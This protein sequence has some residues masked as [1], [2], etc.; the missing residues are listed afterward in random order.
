MVPRGMVLFLP[1]GH[2]VRTAT[3]QKSSRTMGSQSLFLCAA[4]AVHLVAPT[5][6]STCATIRLRRMGSTARS[7]I[8]IGLLS[9]SRP[10]P[11]STL[12]DSF[13]RVF[14]V[15]GCCRRFTWQDA[16]NFRSLLS[17]VLL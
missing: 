13:C 7:R 8:L 16:L 14:L 6:N 3:W 2:S 12:H 1:A 10:G 9:T 15:A 5:T 17:L 11:I 4:V